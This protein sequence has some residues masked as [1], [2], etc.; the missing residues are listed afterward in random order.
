MNKINFG[1]FIVL[2][3]FVAQPRALA[4]S[5]EDLAK[6]SYHLFY[7]G[8][9][10]TPETS[11]G[12]CE[13]C[14]KAKE[15]SIKKLKTGVNS[16]AKEIL[17]S[18]LSKER[19]EDETCAIDF[20]RDSIDKKFDTYAPVMKEK[21][22]RLVAEMHTAMVLRDE[23]QKTKLGK[24]NREKKDQQ[25][26]IRKDLETVMGRMSL[27]EK[28]IPLGEEKHFK[29]LILSYVEKAVPSSVGIPKM[30]PPIEE[31][32]FHARL[33]QAMK[34]ALQELET[35]REIYKTGSKDVTKLDRNAREALAQDRD[36]IESYLRRNPQLNLEGVACE[37][38][39]EYGAGAEI[40]DQALLVGSVAA[41]V[42]SMGLGGIAVRATT[43]AVTT[44]S[45]V[46]AAT[47]VLSLQ[48]ARILG[49]SALV[50][51]ASLAYNNISKNCG[52]LSSAKIKTTGSSD[53]KRCEGFTAE[54]LKR[55]D[56]F[57]T[58]TLSALQV[59][60]GALVV[61]ANELKAAKLADIPIP[62]KVSRQTELEQLGTLR[63]YRATAEEVE[64][65]RKKYPVLAQRIDEFAESLRKQRMMKKV[66]RPERILS[67]KPPANYKDID[68][69]IKETIVAVWNRLNDPEAI[70]RYVRALAEDAA[71][72][73][74]KMGNAKS[75]KALSDG[76][77]T[78]TAVARVLVKRFRAQ[79]NDKFSTIVRGDVEDYSKV[80]K[81]RK[82][83]ED[84]NFRAAVGQGP[85]F[86]KAL[87][88]AINHGMMS[89]AIQ[90]D[91][92]ADVVWKTM[93]G[94]PASYRQYLA[95]K[96]GNRDWFNT[97]DNGG[98]TMATAEHVMKKLRGFLKIK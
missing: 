22:E 92:T 11:S 12:V 95:T 40:R 37:L 54:D 26:K 23:L 47:G 51:D 85:F 86:D 62:A 68:P 7:E 65:V 31:N 8:C 13:S 10:Q 4:L 39:A 55:Q 74:V 44:P 36:L 84:E 52:D 43:A 42:A 53:N 98:N 14:E 29:E 70:A 15:A 79:G 66:R 80:S 78:E 90:D 81:G 50:T 9:S 34:N 58:W 32:D 61:A 60:G 48:S 6:G 59:G 2:L 25:A 19:V 45:R 16:G 94:N 96:R 46:A 67:L 82:N 49:V 1:F 18:A 88:N 93:N 20:L 72:E 71:V 83:S 76:E 33:K 89:H 17:L 35:D 30:P 69:E 3:F 87:E 21:T 38:D 63:T 97:R 75:L 64:E 77:F 56:C 41:S 24:Q 91:M 28:S 57:L 27:I 5:F 73:M